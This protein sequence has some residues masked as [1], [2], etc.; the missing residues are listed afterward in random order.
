MAKFIQASGIDGRG[1]QYLNIDHVS[2]FRHGT[3]D[4]DSGWVA[5]DYEGHDI[6]FVAADDIAHMLSDI[7]P[8]QLGDTVSLLV[9]VGPDR[10]VCSAT[11]R[12]F[13]WSLRPAHWMGLGRVVPITQH[14]ELKG[15]M[16]RWLVYPTADGH[17]YSPEGEGHWD[18]L[19]EATA[20][21]ADW[22]KR[23]PGVE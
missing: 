8:A 20:A 14:G 16:R 21:F 5:V 11:H 6:G 4:G 9:E 12:V 7:V 23:N 10:Y 22:C 17:F 13:A 2:R 1:L 3:R 15:S 18:T 19:E